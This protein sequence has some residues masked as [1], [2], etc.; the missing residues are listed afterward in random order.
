MSEPI[1]YFAYLDALDQLKARRGGGEDWKRRTLAPG[2]MITPQ[3]RVMHIEE[4]RRQRLADLA[5][6]ASNEV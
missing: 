4:W 6:D 1:G 3:G 2:F 5:K